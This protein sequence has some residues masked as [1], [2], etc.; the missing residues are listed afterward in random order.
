MSL[1]RA[2]LE[3]ALNT[4]RIIVGGK[5]TSEGALLLFV[6]DPYY[7]RTER[8]RDDDGPLNSFH[9]RRIMPF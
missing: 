2:P 1:A 5:S 4:A 8:K 6:P 7:P 3:L 9:E